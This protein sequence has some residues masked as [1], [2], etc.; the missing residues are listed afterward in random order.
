MLVARD[1]G[2]ALQ[3]IGIA[4]R[5]KT[6][7]HPEGT[8]FVMRA[9][10]RRR[11]GEDRS[12]YAHTQF[13]EHQRPQNRGNYPGK[14]ERPVPERPQKDQ[15]KKIFRFTSA[16]LLSFRSSGGDGSDSV[17]PSGPL[18]R[19]RGTPSRRRL[20]TLHCGSGTSR[21]GGCHPKRTSIRQSCT[22][23]PEGAPRP[24]GRPGPCAS[25]SS[26]RSPLGER[27]AYRT[28]SIG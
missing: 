25:T 4:V 13:H 16:R 7:W 20:S 26:S 24:G 11:E 9:G 17:R 2:Y 5:W 6:A 3:L 8:C 28:P 14:E 1:E 19:G 22:G 18:A 23:S 21:R 27:R 12:R 15:T 10:P